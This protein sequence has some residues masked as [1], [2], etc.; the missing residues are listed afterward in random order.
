MLDEWE[1]MA[2]RQPEADAVHHERERRTL[3]QLLDARHAP[4][5]DDLQMLEFLAH[6]GTP[7]IVVATKIDK[8]TRSERQRHLAELEQ[9]YS[10]PVTPTS[11][12]TGEGLDQLWK[13]IASLTTTARP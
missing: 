13:T 5:G 4:S 11:A 2:Q 9:V 1:A 6:L 12:D 8:L 10:R 3:V 7:T